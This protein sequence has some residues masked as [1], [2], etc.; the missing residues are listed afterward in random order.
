MLGLK[1]VA[2]AEASR[3]RVSAEEKSAAPSPPI[4]SRLAAVP[5]LALQ[6]AAG[7]AAV[8]R[9]LRQG[10]ETKAGPEG[11]QG[12]EG[13]EVKLSAIGTIPAHEPVAVEV[14]GAGPQ[15]EG[16]THANYTSTD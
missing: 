1:E 16:K 9:I 2:P 10:D 3:E 5:V 14:T 7:N 8:L 15:L 12:A 11:A 4:R 6:G 13:E